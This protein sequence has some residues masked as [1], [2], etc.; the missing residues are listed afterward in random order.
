MHTSGIFLVI[1]L[2]YGVLVL[3][4][5]FL[6]WIFDCPLGMDIPDG[7]LLAPNFIFPRQ[8][9]VLNLSQAHV[10]QR[11]ALF[12]RVVVAVVIDRKNI[13]THCVQHIINAN[14]LLSGEVTVHSKHR[15]FF[16]LEFS[17]VEDM[18]FMLS[19]GP[20]KVQSCLMILEKWC[21]N[22]T[23]SNLKV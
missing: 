15:N 5:C 20:W 6:F 16:I 9:P 12:T 23:I 19:S 14:W 18:N 3:V 2:C 17:E 7:D 13:P 8:G 11:N 1:S 10:Q 22:M 21:P 4:A